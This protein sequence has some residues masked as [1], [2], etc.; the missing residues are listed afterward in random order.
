MFQGPQQM[1]VLVLTFSASPSE[2]EVL[3]L[4]SGLPPCGMGCSGA[5]LKEPP[6]QECPHFAISVVA[7]IKLTSV[8][9]TPNPKN[10]AI[11]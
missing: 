5:L 2:A 6:F 11:I 3:E 8:L 10:H 7:E 1:A 4:P 9:V